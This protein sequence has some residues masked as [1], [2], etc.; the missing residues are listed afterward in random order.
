MIALLR[1]SILIQSMGIKVQ[2]VSKHSKTRFGF[3]FMNTELV[4]LSMESGL[5]L[6]REEPQMITSM[7]RSAPTRIRFWRSE[8]KEEK[9]VLRSISVGDG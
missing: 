1:G 4:K 3:V 5:K 9:K 7:D 6:R 2:V 8:G